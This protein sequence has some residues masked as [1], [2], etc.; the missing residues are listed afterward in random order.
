MITVYLAD[1][2]NIVRQGLVSLLKSYAN[3]QIVGE[4]AD[5]LKA[6]K[7]IVELKPDV[8]IVDITMPKMNGMELVKQVH[9]KC[10]ETKLLV[11]TMHE[12]E[13]YVIHMVKAGASGYLLKDSAGEELIDAV[14]TLAQG[15]SYFSQYAAQ[16]LASQYSN[17][18]QAWDDPYKGLTKRERQIF[19]LVIDG[20]TTKK[21]AEMLYISA[22]TVENHRG[23]ILDKLKVSNTAELV[24]YA[25][26]N[27]LLI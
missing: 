24:K 19:H 18:Q 17:P 23:K 3:C 21:I 13:E 10:P 7:D 9:T 12:E 6:L 1:D 26:K 22:K 25:A 8:A 20:I 11:L 14:K 15:K 2:H 16:V 27:N 4:A 5:G